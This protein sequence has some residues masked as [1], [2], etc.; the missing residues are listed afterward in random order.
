MED[1]GIVPTG[2][3]TYPIAAPRQT[4]RF[5]F[6]I[7]PEFTLL[8]FSSAL[9]PLRIA[10]QLAQRPLYSWSVAS[11]TGGPVLSSSGVAVEADTAISALD[12][13]SHLLVCSGN[14][15]TEVASER[16][17]GAIRRHARF[18]GRI[19]GVCTGAASLARAGLLTGRRFTLHWENQPGFREVFPDLVPTLSR[20][21]VDGDLMTSGGGAAATEMMVT[22]ID[23]DYGR[24]FAIAVADMCLNGSDL[25]RK[26]DQR[27]SIGKAIDSRN[28]KV[29]AVL[30]D[31]Y[32]HIEEPLELTELAARAEVSRRQ[33]ERQ[34]QL[35]LGETPSATYRNIRL[36]RARSLLV[37]TDMSLIDVA[38]AT[39]FNTQTVFSRHF[40]R[41]FGVSPAGQR[42]M[43]RGRKPG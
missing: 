41:R 13:A 27:S 23:E 2:A 19:G 30:R 10:N 1:K 24:D 16:V 7:L 15:G 9:D 39:G 12:P 22:L 5:T 38:M 14:R 32:A 33:L 31:M 28:P 25:D 34:F 35:L 43:S 36:D 3:F 20:Y 40:K 18:G 37:E 21:E 42:G 26:R 29:L 11:E 8:A 17:I 4:R 6:L